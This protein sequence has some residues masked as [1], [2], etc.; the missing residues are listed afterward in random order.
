ME[1][2][3]FKI[4][5]IDAVGFARF[6]TYLVLLFAVLF[7]LVE[8]SS[9]RNITFVPYVLFSFGIVIL[10]LKIKWGILFYLTI[11]LLS[12]DTPYSYSTSGFS[13]VH[14]TQIAGMTIMAL[15]TLFVL[16]WCICH[17]MQ[18]MRTK[19][20][21]N[22][23]DKLMLI[24]GLLFGIEAVL[25]LRHSDINLSV[26]V[27]DFSYFI[28]MGIAYLAVRL[29]CRDKQSLYLLLAV[30]VACLIVRAGAGVV[31]FFAGIGELAGADVR[32]VTDSIR[33]IFPLLILLD[34]AY[35]IRYTFPKDYIVGRLFIL[36]GIIGMFN[37]ITYASR[38]NMVMTF[39]GIIIL[40]MLSRDYKP[41]RRHFNF[42]LKSFFK[43]VISVIIL[44]NLTLWSMETI[45]HSSTRFVSWKLHSLT[46]INPVG[47]KI[48]SAS[49]RWL[50]FKNIVPYLW[51]RGN[52]LWGEGLGGWFVDKYYPFAT[53]L[54]GGSAYPDAWIFQGRLYKPHGTP[55]FILLK[56][57]AGGLVVYYGILFMIFIKGGNVFRMCRDPL[58]KMFL[59]AIISF[60]PLLFYK[61]FISKMQVFMGV[62]I[63]IIAVVQNFHS[64]RH[65]KYGI[66]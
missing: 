50:E 14:I 21:L 9:Y 65:V 58:L 53:S 12:T 56:M 17:I 44:T 60:M 28:N 54:L 34:L 49:T 51:Y 29:I 11:N 18:G 40:I 57:G 36:G 23:I 64:A 31:C 1:R 63:G 7:T 38:G 47:D 8:T 22:H 15:W 33:N 26:F 35:F 42:P 24:M 27:S 13:S 62:L 3:S 19:V 66:N 52:I 25:G 2:M 43:I 48:S 32:A 55:L 37:L 16:F 20:S 6:T 45:R 30:L 59:L 4:S 61:N 39:I 46:M 41:L 10:I 5:G